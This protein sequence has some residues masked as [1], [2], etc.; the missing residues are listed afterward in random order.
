MTADPVAEKSGFL[1]MYMSNHPDTLV[2]YVRYWGKVKENV[3]SATMTEIDT[4]VRLHASCATFKR[5]DKV[6]FIRQGMGFKYTV[7]APGGAETQKETRVH[8]QPPLAGYEDVKPRLLKM[9]VDAEEALGMV[10]PNPSFFP[11]L[12][13]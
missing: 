2:L 5:S 6:D 1:C 3:V 8:F 10:R 13:S 12:H 7:K 9:K 4:K 11:Y